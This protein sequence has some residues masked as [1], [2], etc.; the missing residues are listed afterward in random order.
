MLLNELQK[1]SS[2]QNIPI[3]LPLDEKE[4]FD[5]CCPNP[6]CQKQFK[7]K[8]EDWKNIVQDEQ[9]YCPVCKQYAPA[10]DWNTPEQVKYIKSVSVAHIQKQIGSAFKKDALNFN[11]KQKPGLVS[12]SLDYK[13]GQAIISIPP[14]VESVLEQNY[15][16]NICNC[17]YSYLGTAYFCPAC[18]NENVEGNLKEWIKNIENFTLHFSEI[19]K[20]FSSLLTKED[21][22]SYIT[23]LIEEHF[24]K[25]VTIFQVYSEQLFKSKP[26]AQNMKIRKNIFQNIDDSSKKWSELTGKSLEDIFDQK[27]LTDIKIK[28]QK[29]HLLTHRNGIVD[30]EYLQKTRQ[31]NKRFETDS[32]IVMKN[33]F[34]CARHFSRQCTACRSSG[35]YMD[36][37]FS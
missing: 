5:R 1:L 33:A 22:Q 19:E 31:H 20:N 11:R 15:E 13:P 16:C 12:M 36:L 30:E 35:C 6:Q 32:P 24:C 10:T 17:R 7:V 8:F 2:G 34:R 3:S 14:S 18:G 26:S 4:Y 37:Y 28:F 23:Q 25:V 9:V 29:R 21:C 27:K